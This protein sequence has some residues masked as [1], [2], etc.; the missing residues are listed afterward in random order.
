M[1]TSGTRA[2]LRRAENQAIRGQG[3]LLYCPWGQLLLF[4]PDE[5]GGPGSSSIVGFVTLGVGEMNWS[6]KAGNCP[7]SARFVGAL[8][9]GAALLG[10]F[11]S[12]NSS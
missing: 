3:R 2:T 6:C 5:A 8:K 12:G 10:S 1:S 11:R 7:Q 9:I 4:A